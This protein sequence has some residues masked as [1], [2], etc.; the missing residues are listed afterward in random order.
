MMGPFWVGADMDR[1]RANLPISGLTWSRSEVLHGPE[2][3]RRWTLE[4]K[5]LI[6]AEGFAPGVV[7]SS[8][9]CRHGVHP[10]QLYAWRRELCDAASNGWNSPVFAPVVVAQ[11]EPGLPGDR[12]K[13]PSSTIE[14]EIAGTVVRVTRESDLELLTAVARALKAA[15]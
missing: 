8:V 11:A 12:P 9:A 1:L 5:S 13:E 15:A 14:V 2:R 6:V 4:Q 10:N 3:R 7:T